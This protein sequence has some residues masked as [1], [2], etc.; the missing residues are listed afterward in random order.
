MTPRTDPPEAPRPA[1]VAVDGDPGGLTGAELERRY[2][3]DYEVVL[4]TSGREALAALAEL[5]RRGTDVALVLAG[6]WLD[7]L[8]GAELLARVPAL[9]PQARRALLVGWRAWADRATSD[10]MLRAMALGHIDYYIV[11]PGRRADEQFHR[12]VSEFLDEWS[13]AQGL[14]AA[15]ITVIGRRWAPRSHEL[16]NLLARHGT[17]HTFHASDSVQGRVLLEEHGLA[18]TAGTVAIMLDGSVLVDPSNAELA[19]AF[20]VATELE[21]SSEFDVVVVG[22]G[23]A[24]L[25]A[26]VY[27]SSEGLDVLV[28]EREA[29]GGQ[30]GS[31]SLIR[32]YLGFQRGLSGG[33]MAQRAYQQAWVFGARFLMMR[34]VTGLRTE[35]GRHVLSLSGADE[36]TAEA[37][38]L[39]SGVAYRRIGIASLEELTGSGVFYGASIAEARGLAGQHVCVVGAGNSAGQAAVHL[40][41]EASR[42]SLIVRE[43]SLEQDMSHYLRRAIAAAGNIDVRLQTEVVDAAGDGHLERLT[44]R[45]SAS[46]RTFDLDAAALFLLIGGQ[47]RT[48]WLPETIAR[49]PRGYVLTG[50]AGENW[51]LDRPPLAFETSLPG[52]FAVGDVARMGAGRIAAAVGQGSVVIQQVHE[53]LRRR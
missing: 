19:A 20:G 45:E 7:D 42:V 12:A 51:P 33:D 5:K 43:H 34:E 23:P 53:H 24:G 31:T 28:V 22:A 10:A 26:A 15:E 35:A 9:Y 41:R 8:A 3:A 39:A 2:G 47:P 40:A 16:R 38:V 11:R 48:D 13:R 21:D 52:V 27:A 17:A 50:E 37:V 44:L 46:G 30:A 32:N 14:G 6:Q 4:K 36:V 49:D 1:L 29:I 18:G 25:A